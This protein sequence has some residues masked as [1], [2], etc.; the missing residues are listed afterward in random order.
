MSRTVAWFSAGAAS[1]C[2]TALA[3]LHDPDTVAAYCDPGSEHEDTQRYINDVERW[4]GIQVLMLKSPTYTDTWDVFDKTR[5]LVGAEGARC[6]TELKKKLRQDFQRP[7]DVQVFGFTYEEEKRADQ[8]RKMNPEVN[9]WTPLVDEKM[10]KADCHAMIADAGIEPHAM[11]RLGYK[12]ANCVGCVKGG[13][14]YWNKIRVDFPDVF[15]R[16]A[17]VERSIGISVNRGEHRDPITNKRISDPI[18]LDELEPGRGRYESE[19]S[20]ECGVLCPVDET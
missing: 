17:A 1:S 2:A 11:Y 12:N 4:L 10:T 19:P 8:F 15:N 20:V 14:G 5:Y 3:L 7:D 13:M 9:L 18:F 6:T 16:M